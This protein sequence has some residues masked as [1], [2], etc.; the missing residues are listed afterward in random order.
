MP[1]CNKR[2]TWNLTACLLISL[3]H[4]V[5]HSASESRACN[6]ADAVAD[7]HGNLLRGGDL[8]FVLADDH[9]PV[10]L[11]LHQD[12]DV[13]CYLL[14]D[15]LASCRLQRQVVIPVVPEV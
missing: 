15:G 8:A 13:A 4:P 9:T 11:A 14:R 10:A 12:I 3:R 2:R 5:G 7:R 6:R 1:Y